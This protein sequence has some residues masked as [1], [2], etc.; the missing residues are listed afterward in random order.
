MAGKEICAAGRQVTKSDVPTR[1]MRRRTPLQRELLLRREASGRMP[2][3]GG[4]LKAKEYLWRKG[5]KEGMPMEMFPARPAMGTW[6]PVIARPGA[7]MEYKY[8]EALANSR[9]QVETIDAGV[10]ARLSRR[11]IKKK[12][13]I[14]TQTRDERLHTGHSYLTQKKAT[15]YNLRGRKE[16]KPK[17]ETKKKKK[18]TVAPKEV[19]TLKS[20]TKVAEPETIQFVNE[21]SK[22]TRAL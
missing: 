18:K 14:F 6:P 16:A 10:S 12:R 7:P 5:K 20:L 11:K 2:V 3:E 15:A 1:P 17:V 19:A 13:K 9:M 21:G 8:N 22:S 4:L